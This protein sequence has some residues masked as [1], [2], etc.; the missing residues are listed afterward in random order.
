MKPGGF[1]RERKEKK[2][3]GRKEGERRILLAQKRL[4]L[5][6]PRSFPLLMFFCPFFF[7]TFELY[8]KSCTFCPSLGDEEALL[9]Y[10]PL[11]QDPTLIVQ[12]LSAPDLEA[13]DLTSKYLRLAKDPVFGSKLCQDPL[14]QGFSQFTRKSGNFHPLTLSLSHYSQGE[15]E[16]N[17][18]IQD[19]IDDVVF[20]NLLPE[21]SNM[22]EEKKRVEAR[23][24]RER[25]PV[26]AIRALA[27]L[28]AAKRG[29]AV[30]LVRGKEV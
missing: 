17:D 9:S 14:A 13:D 4:K 19:E 3:K 8:I 26:M 12:S 1:L 15:E 28:V 2:P 21:G 6:L 11:V 27:N 22:G 24:M 30:R 10:S 5:F 7:L 25:M 23:L 16:G 29:A 18:V 20:G